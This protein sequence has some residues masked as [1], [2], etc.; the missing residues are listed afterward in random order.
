[1]R[2]SPTLRTDRWNTVNDEV[3]LGFGVLGAT[4]LAQRPRRTCGMLVKLPL[5]RPG[6]NVLGLNA[7]SDGTGDQDWRSRLETKIKDQVWRSRLGIDA[8]IR[9]TFRRCPAPS[10]QT[11]RSCSAKA[12]RQQNATRSEIAGIAGAR[13]R[14][15][16]RAGARMMVRELMHVLAQDVKACRRIIGYLHT[17]VMAYARLCNNSSH[18]LRLRVLGVLRFFWD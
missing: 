12:P 5:C 9:T 2:F 14:G 3:R 1:M 8:V 18:H 11:H 4:E 10:L 15:I 7:R 13:T 17:S 6:W 16:G